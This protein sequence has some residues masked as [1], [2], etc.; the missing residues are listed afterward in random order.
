MEAKGWDK[1]DFQLVTE[2]PSSQHSMPLC[3]NRVEALVFTVGHP[4]LGVAKTLRLCDAEIADVSGPEV[5][6]LVSENPYYAHAK[7]PAAIYPGMDTPVD[8]FGVL[9]TLVSSADVNEDA[10]YAFVK[11]VFENFDKFKRMHLV[12]RDLQPETMISQGLS[13]P[14]HPGALR[15]Y[16]ERGWIAE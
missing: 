11:S 1:D 14:L 13:A 12:F 9:A 15:Y 8:T 2:L 3:H 5:D 6:K 4:N 7:I 16:R 10:V